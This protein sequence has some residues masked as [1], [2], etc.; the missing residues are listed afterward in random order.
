MPPQFW[1]LR[2]LDS[3]EVN[4]V[5]T[6]GQQPN[7]QVKV[8]KVPAYEEAP[9]TCALPLWIHPLIEVIPLKLINS[10][11]KFSCYECRDDQTLKT[12]PWTLDQPRQDLMW[13]HLI[14][15]ITS[16]INLGRV[17]QEGGGRS[18]PRNIDT[19]RTKLFWLSI[20]ASV[21]SMKWIHRTLDHGPCTWTLLFALQYLYLCCVVSAITSRFYSFNI[22]HAASCLNMHTFKRNVSCLFGKNPHESSFLSIGH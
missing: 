14:L 19:A 15:L 8:H 11:M 4:T 9:C 16:R 6:T 21:G 18:D 12:Q 22:T 7:L 5:K 13:T 10:S 1:T 3:S 2:F 20:L 17:I